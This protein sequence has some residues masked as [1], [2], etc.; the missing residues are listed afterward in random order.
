MPK[1]V[2][3]AYNRLG[4]YRAM[5]EPTLEQVSDE[6]LDIESRTLALT[7]ENPENIERVLE[8]ENVAALLD[9]PGA[10]TRDEAL[11]A[12]AGDTITFALPDRVQV[13]NIDGVGFALI[14]EHPMAL[15]LAGVILL[16]AML[17]AVVL[18]RKQIEIGEEAKTTQSDVLGGGGVV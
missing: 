7:V 4:V 12:G 15:E 5:E 18:A 13:T 10:S 11:T 9:R 14:A 6:R 1:K 3:S 2:V 8:N 16:M 17:G